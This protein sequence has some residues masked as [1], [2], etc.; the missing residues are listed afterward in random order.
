MKKVP[1]P[2]SDLV[3]SHCIVFDECISDSNL[4]S[5]LN[6]DSTSNKDICKVGTFNKLITRIKMRLHV[7]WHILRILWPGWSSSRIKASIWRRK[8]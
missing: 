7:G 5:N 8:K 2:Y 1:N 6:F 3:K 4:L